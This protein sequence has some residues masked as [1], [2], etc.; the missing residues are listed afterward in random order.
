VNKL[1]IVLMTKDDI[2]FPNIRKRIIFD[3]LS[4]KSS[5]DYAMEGN[6]KVVFLFEKTKI[7]EGSG[8]FY[9]YAVVGEVIQNKI[10]VD[11]NG[12][13]I[14]KTDFYTKE[15]IL[16]P[17]ISELKNKGIFVLEDYIPYVEKNKIFEKENIFNLANLI[18][19]EMNK[20]MR[21]LDK[22][23]F[24]DEYL[25]TQSVSTIEDVE[26]YVSEILSGLS[27]ENEKKYCYL[28]E[29]NLERRLVMLFEYLK[30]RVVFISEL[31]VI[32]DRIDKKNHFQE[33]VF[34]LKDKIESYQN[35]LNE[36][37][38]Y[39]E[40]PVKKYTENLKNINIPNEDNE[41]ILKEINKLNNPNFI[42]QERAKVIEYVETILDMPFES[43]NE[44]ERNLLKVEKVLNSYHY[45]A[46]K[47][48]KKI[49]ENLA[50]HNV[51]KTKTMPVMCLYGPPGVGKTSFG[52]SI[53]KAT[54]RKMVRVS[55]G[56]VENESEIRGHRR[57]Y[58]GAKMGR[59][60]LAIKESGVNN[61]LILLDE[62]DKINTSGSNSVSSALLEVLDP[63]QNKNFRD[64]YLEVG[65]DLS[66]VMFLATA[67]SLNIPEPLLDRMD[68]VSLSGYTEREKL[69]IVKNHTLPKILN[70]LTISGFNITDK[71]IL[72]IINEY[73]QESGVRN[74][75]RII[76]SFIAKSIKDSLLEVN[77]SMFR[78][79][80]YC[81]NDVSHY[82]GKPTFKMSKVNDIHNSGKVNGLA[83]S[84]SGGVVLIVES[85]R[86]EG[87]GKMALTGHLGDVMKE[88]A[89]A[90][91][92]IIK[93]QYPN[94]AKHLKSSDLHVHL[95]EGGVPKDGPSAG[96]ALTVSMISALSGLKVRGDVAM[97]GEVTLSGDVI[98]VGG[99]KEK[100][101]AAVRSGIKKVIIPK[102]N[103]DDIEDIFLEI[104]ENIEIVAIE[105]VSE[106]VKIA[107]I[108]KKNNGDY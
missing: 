7:N 78:K 23:N 101:L 69:F 3:R 21:H 40:N 82:L 16:V 44:L 2:F 74:L 76:Y 20:M 70:D 45:G 6:K 92:T 43:K 59:I 58:V 77:K 46:N 86:T 13:E 71:A 64:N 42:D 37:T 35:E 17:H 105:K 75:E 98:S 19:I 97:T 95:P 33:Q 32:N 108:L 91:L 51:S 62:I 31:D 99:V 47:V 68:V 52:T 49:L 5:I 29:L 14:Y 36:L 24:N 55:L 104:K 107:L 8:D 100:V 73:T 41:I 54:G 63:N 65:F 72:K 87:T 88:S 15:R 81:V 84:Q 85:L 102:D 103:L 30:D 96:V 53:A 25:T 90:A 67:N 12:K 79:N 4:S 66:N 10:D 94:E 60:L 106:A 34:Y 89:Q 1:P 9:K 83:W 28:K 39:S 61:P 56:G 50:V 57:T 38:G 18:K 80:I 22:I 48:K 11:Q 93:T 26:T 27:I